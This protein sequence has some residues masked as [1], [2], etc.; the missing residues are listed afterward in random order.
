LFR[1]I[2]SVI[3]PAYNAE[4]YIPQ[5]IKSVICQTYPNW[6]LIVVDDGSTD[7]TAQIIK[8]FASID[9]RI[10]Y[11]FQDNGKQ[12]KARNTGIE[13]AEGELIA[14]VDADDIWFPEKLAKQVCF[15]NQSK[16]DLVFNDVE[17]MDENG[18]KLNDSWSVENA[19]YEGSEGLSLFLRR[20]RIPA[21]TALV[22]KDVINRAGGFIECDEIQYG[23]DYELWLR[24][25]Q[26]GAVFAG[27]TEKLGA[28]RVH[29][30]QAT[31]NKSSIM[32]VLK[33]INGIKATGAGLMREKK[34]AMKKWIRKFLK[35]NATN[36]ITKRE[37]QKIISFYPDKILKNIFFLLYHFLHTRQLAKIVAASAIR[38]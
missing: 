25:L 30:G 5:S 9:K 8:S 29:A 1:I 6:E 24:L 18:S 14:F 36:G 12:G 11:V 22:K 7:S 31:S 17:V 10:K 15:M 28:Y 3:M 37:L 26:E 35:L 38:L 27:N 2:I 33:T 23:E 4:K 13:N 19:V 34:R 20:N 16:A 21:L 32:Q